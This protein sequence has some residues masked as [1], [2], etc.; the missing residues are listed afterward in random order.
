SATDFFSTLT[1]PSLLTASY[2][3]VYQTEGLKSASSRTLSTPAARWDAYSHALLE[4]GIVSRF[5]VYS[6]DKFRE[7]TATRDFR[8]EPSE[9]QAIISGFD[10]DIKLRLHGIKIQNEAYTLTRMGMNRVMM[11]GRSSVDGSG[12]VIYLCRTCVL[13]ALHHDGPQTS[14]CFNTIENIGDYLVQHGF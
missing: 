1:R 14:L 10:D 8:L 7:W 5:A 2:S 11:V 13:V 12:C 4:K 9:I 3:S 6:R